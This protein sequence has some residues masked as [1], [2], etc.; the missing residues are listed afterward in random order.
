MEQQGL[1]AS[2]E[3]IARALEVLGVAVIALAFAHA[4]VL[5]LTRLARRQ[6]NTYGRLR[7]Y[8]G[9]ALLLGLEFLVAADIIMTV[10]LKPTMESLQGLGLLVAVRIILGWSISMEVDGCWPWQTAGRANEKAVEGRDS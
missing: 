8:L 10:T 4:L 9:R 5:A 2:I 3:F 1:M 6:V 7:V